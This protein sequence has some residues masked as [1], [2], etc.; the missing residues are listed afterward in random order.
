MK[1]IRVRIYGASVFAAFGCITGFLS[2]TLDVYGKQKKCWYIYVY[3]AIL[4][5]VWYKEKKKLR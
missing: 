2:G 5:Q 3:L 1:L 4:Q